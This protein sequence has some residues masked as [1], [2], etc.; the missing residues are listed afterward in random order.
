[1][2]TTD[3]DQNRV[4]A[5]EDTL[6]QWLRVAATDGTVT[7][8]DTTYRPETHAKFADVDDAAAYVD[9]V[10]SHLCATGATFDGR[11]QHPVT[12]RV[13]RGHKRAVYEHATSTIAIPDRDHGGAWALNE[14]TVL[15]EIAHH[16]APARAHHGPE[17]RY[18]FVRLLESVGKTETAE[19]LWYAY[20][21]QGLGDNDTATDASMRVAARIGKL[22]RQSEGASTEAERDAFL[23]RAQ[24]IAT[25]HSIALAAARA[26]HRDSEKRARPEFRTLRTGFAG[27]KGLRLRVL[28]AIRLCNI[29]DAHSFISH[30]Q[31]RVTLLGYG[32]DLDLIEAMYASLIVQMHRD[33]A[34]YLAATPPSS[35][36]ERWDDKTWKWKPVATITAKLAFQEGF[37]RSVVDRLRA[38]KQAALDDALDNDTDN[39]AGTALVLRDKQLEVHD[40]VEYQK[41]Q[42][43]IRGTWRHSRSYAE[44]APE[45]AREGR[46]AGRSADV[47]TGPRR[48]DTKEHTA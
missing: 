41:R 18:T 11:E 32:E 43:G 1:M 20:R 45:A 31:T 23:A 34:A 13:R 28:L 30:D 17:F 29:N 7:I 10:M 6:E 24:Q 48:I 47:G 22:L 2:S 12:V 38:A 37:I 36:D 15:H 21:L 46:L 39:A 42:L 14:L 40:F 3:P 8:D 26:T 25:T 33:T 19:L 35:R 5:A 16:L 4:Y 44:D 27:E 9:Q